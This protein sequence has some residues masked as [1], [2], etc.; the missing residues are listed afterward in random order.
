MNNLLQRSLKRVVNQ[1]KLIH[2][3]NWG[4]LIVLDACRYD[5][6]KHVIFD[7]LD[8]SLIP[9]KSCGSW[10]LEWFINT[11]RDSYNDIIYVSANPLIT[12][13]TCSGKLAFYEI[14]EVHRRFW[15]NRILSVHP[16]MVN[17]YVKSLLL[18]EKL[19]G[20]K[21]K[22]KIIHYLQP[23]L[24]YLSHTYIL[25]RYRRLLLLY[26]EKY[27]YSRKCENIRDL[28]KLPRS[29]DLFLLILL[30]YCGDERRM[31]T[32]LRKMYIDN[33]KIVLK[34]VSDL[35]TK[36]EGNVIITSDHGELLGEYGMYFHPDISFPELRIV[37]WFEVR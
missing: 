11:W 19:R 28:L 4:T 3:R 30:E 9:V 20:E 5:I 36:V 16:L 7:Y 15:N 1:K 10:T 26:S 37:P 18:K 8:G 32:L 25:N 12:K 6:F 23:H 34:Y 35:V 13:R 27:Y 17:L 33:L 29:N 22:R 21:Y 24:P 14:K 2:G 31:R